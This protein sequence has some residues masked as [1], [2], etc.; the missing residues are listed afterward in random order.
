M[1]YRG[2]R[3]V[4]A[5]KKERKGKERQENPAPGVRLAVEVSRVLHSGALRCGVSAARFDPGLWDWLAN[6]VAGRMQ[7]PVA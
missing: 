4:T 1:L 2:L 3:L 7:R 5:L 6:G